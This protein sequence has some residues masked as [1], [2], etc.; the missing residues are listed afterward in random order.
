LGERVS[1]LSKNSF[2]TANACDAGRTSRL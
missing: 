1:S 2:L